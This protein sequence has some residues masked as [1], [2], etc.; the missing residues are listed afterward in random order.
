LFHALLLRVHEL[1]KSP[2][3]LV[4]LGDDRRSWLVRASLIT[5]EPGPA[6]LLQLAPVG[7][8][9]V[10][11]GGADPVA[12]DELI[13]RV[14]DG[15]VVLDREGRIL[16][17]NQAF[18]DLVQVAAKGSVLGERLGRW[19]GRPGADLTV[20]LANVQRYGAVR[21]F[22][23]TVQGELGTETEVEISATGS[24]EAEPRHVALLLRDVSQRLPPT[25][26]LRRVGAVLGSLTEQVGKTPLR[27]LVKGAVGAVERHYIEA[28]LDL[29]QGNR[30]AAAEL[31]GLSRQSLYAKLNRYGLDAG[32]PEA[33]RD[34]RD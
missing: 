26:D 31:L 17:V 22:S 25:Q 13:E 10:E 3:I 6:F 12:I 32:E 14:P 19:L 28:A 8:V 23:T 24:S 20:L 15:F 27:S 33:V 21:L 7:A 4:H 2:G 9:R 16:R 1:G 30:T 11:R 18:L 34:Q 29:T 5:T